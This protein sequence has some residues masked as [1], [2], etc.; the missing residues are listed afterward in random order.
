VTEDGQSRLLEG[1]SQYD[2]D[3]VN[4]RL[5]VDIPLGIDPFLLYKSRDPALRAL[6]EQVLNVFNAGIKAVASGDLAEARR[7]LDFPEAEEI[8]FGYTQGG[9]HGSGVGDHLSGLVIDTVVDSPSLQQRGVKHVEEMQLLSAGIGPDRVSDIAANI[10]KRFL[11]EYTQRQCRL[12]NVPMRSAVPVSHVFDPA[13]CEWSDSYEEMP[14]SPFDGS[15]ILLVPRRW[16]RTLP[17][18]NYDDFSRTEFRA[19]LAARLEKARLSRAASG[20]SIGSGRKQDIVT[21][22]RRD[23]ALVDRYV[24]ARERRAAEAV[25]EL[26]YIDEDAAR[27]AEALLRRLEACPAGRERAGDYQRLVLEILNFLFNP[28]LI[29]GKLEEATAEG[30]ER[31]DIVFTNDSD[32]PFWAYVRTEHSGLLL[33][34]ETK[35][36]VDLDMP[37]VNQTATYLGDRLG[38]LGIIVTRQ[39]EA[40]AVRRKLFSVWNDSSPRKVILVLADEHLKELLGLRGIG[41]STTKWMQQHYRRFRA[42]VQ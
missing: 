26:Q 21:A 23:I 3:F 11:I 14:V 17:W 20:A 16:V 19:Y 41:K 25:P 18:I 42:A 30:T 7:I 31:R 1:V 12:W 15:P 33:M 37:A 5:G 34:F 27:Q 36:T 29:D 4:P 10:L 40:D 6:H 28:D 35:N 8:G 2:V 22:T 24:Q 39:A 9:K 13:R 32:E 38:R